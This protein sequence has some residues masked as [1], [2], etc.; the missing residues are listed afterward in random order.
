MLGL[1]YQSE[2]DIEIIHDAI[3]RVE[4]EGDEKKIAKKREE[5]LNDNMCVF[6]DSFQK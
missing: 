1:D 6:F 4:A 5:E 2:N 3:T